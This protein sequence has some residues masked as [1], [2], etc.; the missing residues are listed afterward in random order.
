MQV[1][2]PAVVLTGQGLIGGAEYSED[3]IGKERS[4]SLEELQ[5]MDGVKGQLYSAK[6]QKAPYTKSYFL[7]DGVKISSL[8]DPE[9]YTDEITFLA[10]DGY[11]CSFQKGAKYVN[12]SD[13]KAA[14]LGG[15]RYLY[16]GFTSQERR[17]GQAQAVGEIIGGAAGN[18][19]Q[20]R[21]TAAQLQAGDDLV[22][23]AVPAAGDN[24]IRPAGQIPGERYGI[25]ALFRDID[26][27]EIT[28]PVKDR[29]NLRQETP[30]LA[31]AGVGVDDK[32]KRFHFIQIRSRR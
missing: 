10:A 25:P 21:L 32:I 8:L 23:G 24:Q 2:E 19:A 1:Q 9:A 30:T 6:K 17:G 11:S 12:P 29:D 20:R 22:E 7:A 26:G 15:G 27:A 14:G 4:W 5:T 31:G 16:D 3:T 13:T 28:R 18:V